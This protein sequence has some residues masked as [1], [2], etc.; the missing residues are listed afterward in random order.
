MP[1]TVSGALDDDTPIIKV[2][3]DITEEFELSDDSPYDDDMI[4]V[5][6]GTV[7]HIR[8]TDSGEWRIVALVVGTGTVEIHSSPGGHD[9][10][11]LHLPDG[12]AWVV[13][14]IGWAKVGA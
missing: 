12:A 8:L 9:E 13:H 7:L 5:S 2:S 10:A 6:D 4:A 3:G 11:T 1:I 14:G